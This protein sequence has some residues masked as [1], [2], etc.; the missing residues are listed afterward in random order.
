M[1]Y[2]KSTLALY[3]KYHSE[4]EKKLRAVERANHRTFGYFSLQEYIGTTFEVLGLTSGLQRAIS[5]E[6]FSFSK[7]PLADQFRIWDAIWKHSTIHDEMNQCLLFCDQIIDEA[8]PGDFWNVTRGWVPRLDNWAHSDELSGFFARILEHHPALVYPQLV[9][10]NGSKNPWERRQSLV[11]LICYA[12]SRKKFLAAGKMFPLV[13][14]LLE[15]EH[16]FVQK[17]VG[18]TLRELSVIYHDLTWQ[19]LV[20]HH[21]RISGAAFTAAA[22]KLPPAKKNKL[23]TLRKINRR[24]KKSLR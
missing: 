16:Y 3:K 21:T 18:W 4:V 5:R 17:G 14:H 23:K 22:E 1:P 13:E 24:S 12:R 11:S 20:K 2:N 10:W 15:D 9:E 8:H 6:G 19:F 7:L